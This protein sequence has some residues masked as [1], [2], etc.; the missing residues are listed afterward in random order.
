M[1]AR[2]PLNPLRVFDACARHGSFLK[3]AE[4]LNITPGA[5]SRQIKALETELSL[6][7]FDRLNRAVRL[8]EAGARLATGARQGFTTLQAAVDAA[9]SNRDAPLVVSVLHSVAARWLVPRLHRFQERHPEA[10]I[11][12]DASDAPADLARDGV[13]IA[14]RLGRGP[15]PNLHVT[16]LFDVVLFPVCSPLLIA[17]RGPFK[18]PDD[19]A[20]ATLLRESRLVQEEP[21]WPEWLARAGATPG[22]VD[23]ET[24]PQFSNTYLSIEAALAGRGV[25]LAE[26]AMVLE[27]LA[28]GRLVAPFDYRLETA[29]AF[30]ALSLPERADQPS[31]RR[32]RTWLLDQAKADGLPRI[33]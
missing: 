21:T 17:E 29:I 4:E 14:I 19:L 18:H 13:D 26:R 11:L 24:G 1:H 12:V 31:I 3:A 22:V 7:L 15:Y 32:F 20:R 25:A 5:V 2:L 30:W 8:T 10:Q 28:A 27:D 16:R 23:P 33:R 6:R 9:R